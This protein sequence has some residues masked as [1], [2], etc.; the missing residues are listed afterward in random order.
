MSTEISTETSAESGARAWT[1]FHVFVH[2][3]R[4]STDAVLIAAGAW[5]ERAVA[6]G[7]AS[8][9]FALRYWEGGPHV[10]V[11][12]RDLAPEAQP[13][14]RAALAEAARAAPG[15]TVLDRDRFYAPLATP[16]ERARLDWI[17]SGSVID[18][19]YEP[20]HARYAHR[21]DAAEELFQISSSIAVRGLR[22]VGGGVS[23]TSIALR[24]LCA[25]AAGLVA[26]GVPR[27]VVASALRRYAAGFAGLAG[28]PR[29][30]IGAAAERAER[31]HLA[32][33]EA[34]SGCVESLVADGPASV[35]RIW[36][37]AVRDY[38]L[39]L[40]A[41]PP[42]GTTATE[43]AAPE[44]EGA[45]SLLR[46]GSA[47]AWSALGSQWHMLANRLGVDVSTE[48]R[49]S[50]VVSLALLGSP[51]P[52][53]MHGDGSEA[54]AFVEATKYR[55]SSMARQGPLKGT[56][57][58][59][60]RSDRPMARD[61]RIALPAADRSLLRRPDLADALHDRRSAYGRFDS[62]VGLTGLAT[63]LRLSA[64][65]VDS[66][67]AS[68]AGRV[69]VVR[70]RS[71]PSAGGVGCA[72]LDVA[73]GALPGLPA[74]T[75]RFV[76]ES[77][78][79]V[80]TAADSRQALAA[81]SPYSQPDEDGR[82]AVDVREAAA[83]LHLSLDTRAV[84]GR[85]GQRGLRFALLEAGHLAQNVVLVAT[86]LGWSSITIGGFHDDVLAASSGLDGISELPIYLIPVGIPSA[87][88]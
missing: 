10:R 73:S 70:R 82:V 68:E 79:L 50:W 31:D 86:A 1:A 36:T 6:D 21:M 59:P 3:D 20:E 2:G 23:R 66:Y 34:I 22:A 76:P 56:P 37:N 60:A 19:P 64:G 18:A 15:L 84:L 51:R 35:E 65:I 40:A 57:R 67:D 25:H 88:A 38:A 28:A 69:V 43:A 72:R 9:W 5:C 33:G 49:L 8:A 27:V 71:Y 11:R 24:L 80:R 62:G 29:V 48:V 75:Y 61:L 44:A 81:T 4:S 52:E 54:R 32:S 47:D 45:A 30:D 58:D 26:A 12:L 55:R 77:S 16:E 53:V 85:Y 39:H 78:E 42:H 46:W 63:L 87:R 14:A 83:V 74:G 41:E 7:D 13:R 17:P